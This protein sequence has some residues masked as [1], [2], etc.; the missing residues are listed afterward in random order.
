MKGALPLLSF[1]SI[2]SLLSMLRE[3]CGYVQDCGSFPKKK[4]VE[5]LFYECYTS[6]LA[7]VGGQSWSN[8][9]PETHRAFNSFNKYQM[10]L[11]IA[12]V[13]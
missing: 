11:E 3:G 7:H 4:F 6:C 12:Q 13:S 2:Y 9:M 5:G 10:A 1:F 8:L